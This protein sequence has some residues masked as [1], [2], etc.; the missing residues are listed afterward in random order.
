MQI[1]HILIFYNN[2][3]IISQRDLLSSGKELLYLALSVG[4][5]VGRLVGPIFQHIIA[6]EYLFHLGDDV[7]EEEE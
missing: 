4:W 2:S 1:S 3:S 7:K 6:N 5:S